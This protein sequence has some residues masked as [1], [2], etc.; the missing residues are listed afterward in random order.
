MRSAQVDRI[1]SRSAGRSESSSSIR[2]VEPIAR[3]SKTVGIPWSLF[4]ERSAAP[5]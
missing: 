3:T 4:M 2:T 5:R 1:D